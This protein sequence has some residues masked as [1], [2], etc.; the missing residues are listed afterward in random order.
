MTCPK[1]EAGIL[2]VLAMIWFASILSSTVNSA[3]NGVPKQS[4]WI[5]AN[6]LLVADEQPQ[7][8]MSLGRNTYQQH[9]S[10]LTLINENNVSTLGFAWEYDARS[11][12][13]RV[14]RGL[15]A[16]PIVVDGVMYTSGAWGVVYAVNAAT[17][18]QIWRYDPP[19]DPS[20][21]RHACCDV[22]NRGVQVWEGLVYVG[23]L[24]GYL[25][26]L[27]A[28]SGEVVWRTDTI[29]D[30]NR[31]YTITS[32]PQVA[33]NV[34]VIGNSGA[35]YGVRGYV[36]AYELRTGEQAWR[37]YTVPGDPD[38][39]FE[40]P[41][42]E[43]AAATW[44]PDSLWDCG[45]G[46]T[47]W[48]QMAYD[49]ELDL[50]YIGTGNASPYPIWERSPNGGD[51]LFLAS[52]LAI[53][54]DT[55]RL[56]WYYQ[57]TPAESWDYTATQNIVLADI[58]IAGV[59]RNV[60]MQAPKNGF[61]YVLDRGTGELISAENYVPV[62]WASHIDLDTGKPVLT[63][64]SN[65]RDQPKEICPNATGGHSWMPMSFSPETGLVYI[66]ALEGCNTLSVRED[67]QLRPGLHN[68]GINYDDYIAGEEILKAWNPVTQSE[69]WRVA[70]NGTGNGGLLST[71]GGLV[72]QGTASGH[73]VA[74]QADTGTKL[75]EIELGT[76]VMA[77]PMTY[78]VDGEQYV[79][80]MASLGGVPGVEFSPENAAARY[81]NRGRILSFKLDGGTVPLPPQRDPIPVPPPPELVYTPEDVQRG[82]FFYQDVCSVCHGYLDGKQSLY[83]DLT[84]LDTSVHSILDDIVLGG[85]LAPNGM[86]SFAD[87]LS[88]EDL[89]SIRAFLVSIQRERF[90]NGETY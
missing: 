73:F 47:V 1:I 3:E 46:G 36:T 90:A 69:E 78:A 43:I 22:V 61:F 56:Q 23:T 27:N 26:A 18:E 51:N 53:K 38:N 57:T 4:G 83:P 70:L 19:L 63:A 37:F 48:G 80:V 74:Y 75:L 65:Y 10:T 8:W 81:Q 25:V 72:F 66:P 84:A 54:P 29:T 49:P 24:D 89:E 13:G 2:K 50:L 44:D 14:S 40:H 11:R 7:N 77:A 35:E 17:G 39:G 86:A 16:T 62:N 55:G 21:N 52:L 85:I 41:E 88:N 30:R 64:N 31:S 42:L 45:G 87:V 5:D 82:E 6:R 67:Y 33:K 12:I 15:E 20:Y 32:A 60:L 9:H 79:A 59:E 28:E 58:E 68:V 71:D 34:V 76:S